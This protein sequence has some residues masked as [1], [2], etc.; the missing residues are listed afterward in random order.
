MEYWKKNILIAA[1]HPDDE[2]LGCG[3]TIAKLSAHG[4][5]VSVLILGEGVT[6]RFAKREDGI[7]SPDMKALRRSTNKAAKI[8]GIKSI[9][10]FDFP[11]NRFDSVPTLE[12]VKVIEKVKA[13]VR[14]QVIFTHHYFDLNVDHRVTYNAVLTSFRPASD[15]IAEDIY[16]FEIPSSTEWNYP[17]TFRANVF[18]D[19]SAAMNKKTAALRCYGN[20][21]RKFPHPRSIEAVKSIAKRWGSVS[22]LNAAEAFEAVRIIK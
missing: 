7:K 19:I 21:L 17:N 4:C 2:A 13:E 1:A 15:H 11:D 20:E 18:V 14:P 12:I 10:R 16:S 3:G 8:L 22:G 5:R 6:S 9:F